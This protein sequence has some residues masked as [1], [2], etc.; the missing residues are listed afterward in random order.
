M[1]IT[2]SGL[3]PHLYWPRKQG[4]KVL[5]GDLCYLLVKEKK[6]DT[7]SI[8]T[9]AKF[10]ERTEELSKK[11]KDFVAVLEGDKLES[12][13]YFGNCGLGWRSVT[14]SPDGK[15]RACPFLIPSKDFVLGDIR[16]QLP[17]TVFQNK[18]IFLYRS[19]EAPGPGICSDCENLIFCKGCIVRGLQMVKS[20]RVKCNWYKA[21]EEVLECLF[22]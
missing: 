2:L 16:R 15:V 9:S 5:C 7:V 17:L 19:L 3:N 12:I 22:K 8:V 1:N 10:I 13:D 4:Q 6:F 21:N 20:K 14:L 11:Y 18:K